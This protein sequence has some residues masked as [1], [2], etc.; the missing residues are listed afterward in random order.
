[1]RVSSTL[2]QPTRQPA[3]APGRATVARPATRRRIRR[4]WLWALFFL[5]P[6]LFLF[7]SFTLFPMLFGFGVS[8]FRW[9]VIEPPV[10]VG[11]G[12]YSHFFFGDPQTPQIVRNS[13]V[14]TLGALP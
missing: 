10:F 2:A 14:Y 1:M 9:T 7:L 5:G 12:N 4:E 8:F 3:I 13:L 11:L 6:N